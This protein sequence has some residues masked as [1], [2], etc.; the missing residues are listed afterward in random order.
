MEE[1]LHWLPASDHTELIA[2]PVAAALHGVEGEVTVAAIDP[3]L[4]DTAE[5]CDRY[6]WSLDASANCVIVAGKR[7]GEVR[8][9]AVMV[10]ATMRADVNGVIRKRLDV[11]K[12]SFAPMAEAVELTGMEYGGITPIGLPDDWPILVDS[13]VAA[14][15][16]VVI[17]GG[18]R[19]SKLALSG[20]A[21]AAL[22]G[23]EVLDLAD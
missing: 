8:Y 10:L 22:K 15:P 20:A 1:K 6:G 3:A 13:R 19:H 5:F 17:G 12:S 16:R 21:L 18:V 14:H 11:R 23:A 9:A 2:A 7:G 4:S